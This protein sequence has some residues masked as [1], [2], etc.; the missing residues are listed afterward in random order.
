MKTYGSATI[1]SEPSWC[2]GKLCKM[3]NDDG[4]AKNCVNKSAGKTDSGEEKE[5]TVSIGVGPRS[6]LIYCA[7]AMPSDF[8]TKQV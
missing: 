4:N 6:R 1:F 3:I 5:D 2:G 7:R 8:F